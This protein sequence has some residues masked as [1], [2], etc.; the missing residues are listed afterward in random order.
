MIDVSVVICVKNGASTIRRTLESLKNSRQNEII[1]IDGNSTDGTLDIV[2]EY[3][4]KIF[5]DNGLGLGHARQL[6]AEKSISTYVSYI[7]ADT[8]LPNDMILSTMLDELVQ[9]DWFAIHAQMVDPRLIKSIW[10][11]GEAFHWDHFLNSPG[12]KKSIGTIV[13]IINKQ[14]ILR[15][16]F[17]E[18]I[19]GAAEDADFYYRIRIEGYNFGMS[20]QNAYHYHRSNFTSFVKQ[21]IWY[22]KGNGFLIIKHK[23]YILL[24]TP[25]GIALRGISYSIKYNKY[26]LILF[27][28]VWGITLWFG[29]IGGLFIIKHNK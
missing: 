1:V 14:L 12:I 3:D 17:D 26:K 9:N 11:D 10:D 28:L 6:G 18:S 7:D 15:Y 8:E 13:C 19:K 2:K 4:V 24:F 22:G 16:R 23:A 25:F 5:S 27:Y 21:R 29:T 20:K